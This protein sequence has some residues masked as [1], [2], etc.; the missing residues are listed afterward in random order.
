MILGGMRRHGAKLGLDDRP[1]KIL[2]TFLLNNFLEI[3]FLMLFLISE[4]NKWC[5]ILIFGVG[6]PVPGRLWGAVKLR[7]CFLGEI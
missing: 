4:P 1:L 7:K 2:R 6:K 5:Q 3:L